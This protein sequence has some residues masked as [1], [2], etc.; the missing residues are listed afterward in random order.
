M[1]VVQRYRLP[2]AYLT[3]FSRGKDGMEAWEI[4]WAVKMEYEY[5]EVGAKLVKSCYDYTKNAPCPGYLG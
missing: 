2:N 3:K 4:G 1:E 5:Q